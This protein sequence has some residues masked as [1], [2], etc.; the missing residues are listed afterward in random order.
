M[1]FFVGAIVIVTAVVIIIG[2]Q[3]A[4][5]NTYPHPLLS[6]TTDIQGWSHWR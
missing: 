5:S 3:W 4:D 2:R 1:Y 6:I